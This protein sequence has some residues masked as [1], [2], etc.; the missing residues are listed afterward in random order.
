MLNPFLYNPFEQHIRMGLTGLSRSGKTVFLTSLIHNLLSQKKLPLF[1]PLRQGLIESVILQHQPNDAIARFAYEEHLDCLLQHPPRWP[2]GTKNIS[3]I[4]LSIRYRPQNIIAKSLNQSRVLTLDII[5]Y[6]GEWLLDLPL[7]EMDFSTWSARSIALCKKPARL[8][9]ASPWLKAV[10]AI[11][12][13]SPYEE[14]KLTHLAQ[15]YTDFLLQLRQEG[16]GHFDL[17]PGRFLLPGDLKDAPVL[18]FCPLPAAAGESYPKNSYGAVMQRRFESYKKLVVKPFF[19]KYFAKLNQQII[20]IDPLSALNQGEEALKDLSLSME[21]ILNILRPKAHTWLYRLLLG[22]SLSHVL[23]AA[24]KADHVHHSQHSNLLSLTK[25][26]IPEA[27]R[28]TRFASL[29][30]DVMAIAALRST[31]ELKHKDGRHLVSGHVENEGECA[32]YPGDV[33]PSLRNAAGQL[34]GFKNFMP[35]AIADETQ[36]FDHIRLDQALDFLLKEMMQ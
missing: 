5:D 15:L 19:E 30:M 14:R 10:E 3:Q 25:S 16:K 31:K 26:L 28:Q 17:P 6:P 20:L 21:S 2:E 13:H 29:N 8:A 7:L 35:P 4:R 33:P 18:T 22:R 36:G 23:F 32:I 11:D 27:Y 12:L 24:T 9:Y 34:Y 1:T